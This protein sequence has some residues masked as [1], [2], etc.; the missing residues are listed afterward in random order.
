[1]KNKERMLIPINNIQIKK[2]L[3]INESLS[4]EHWNKG[5]YDSF[6]L[7]HGLGKQIEHETKKPY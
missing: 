4:P 5:M 2:V 7:G 1:M 6:M 3:K